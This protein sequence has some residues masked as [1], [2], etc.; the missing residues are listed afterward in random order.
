MTKLI[1]LLMFVSQV[2]LAKE[3][4]H[5][6]REYDP[7]TATWITKQVCVDK[8]VATE[9]DTSNSKFCTET[10]KIMGQCK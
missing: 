10:M 8:P 2:G 5:D 7:N 3:E 1:V 9:P 6:Q 4:C